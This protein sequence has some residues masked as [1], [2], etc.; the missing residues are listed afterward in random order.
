VQRGFFPKASWRAVLALVFAGL[1]ADIDFLGANFGPCAYL[2]WNR[3]ATHSLVFVAVV[4]LAAFLLTRIFRSSQQV[5]NWTG[6]SWIA[7]TTIVSLHL[8]MDCTQADSIAL[9]WPFSSKRFLLDI[10]PAIDPWLIVVLAAA[11]L[12]PELLRLVGD[13][14]SSRSKSPR[15]RAGA[16]VGLSVA[17]GYFAGRAILHSNVTA[18]LESRTISGEMPRRFAAFP[19]S[20]SPFL[21]HSIVETESALHLFTMRSMGGAVSYA[22][23]VATLRK[24]EPSAMLSA[25]QTSSAAVEFLKTARFPKAVVEQEVEGYSVEI[26]DLKNQAMQTQNQA[27]FADINLDKSAKVTSSE[28][29]WQKTPTRP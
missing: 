4:A 9:L 13:E 5:G 17:L 25:A 10:V 2:R 12:F 1:V 27:V 6:F 18:A 7:V 22:S 15:G 20:V 29:Q 19:D 14:I 24:P 16:I 23:G 8:L 28:L 3:T 11:I 26:N 21:W